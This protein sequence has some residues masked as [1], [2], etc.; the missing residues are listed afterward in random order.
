M[1]ELRGLSAGYGGN[2]VVRGVDLTVREGEIVALVGANGGGKST[3]VKAVSGLVAPLAGE[4][5]FGGKPI[6][7]L[8]PRARVRLGIV[9]VPE[10]RQ[11]F[12]GLS[13]AEN[14]RLG[15]WARRA[16][17]KRAIEERMR[18]IA[19]RFPVLLERLDEPAG[20]LSGGQQQMLAIA[21][22]LMAEPRLLLLDEPSLGLAPLLVVDIFR[23][24][25]ALRARG[26]AVLLAEQNAR[27]SLGIAD[28]GYVIET[29]RVVLQGTGRELMTR[30]DIAERYL[31]V[32]KAVGAQ[33]AA[34]VAELA[35]RLRGVLTARD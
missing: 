19:G 9:H 26:I 1:L 14:L 22:G 16:Q 8:S 3:L 29:G 15:A 13:I 18:E 25:E 30:P 31:G 34:R 6:A 12:A 23:L 7:P 5:F 27:M 32:G 10:G 28:R 2:P 35:A 17:G 33:S 4:I 21:R 24:I 20:T 11:V